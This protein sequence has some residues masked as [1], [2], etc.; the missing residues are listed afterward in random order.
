MTNFTPGPWK[1]VENG[2]CYGHDVVAQDGKNVASFVRYE[3]AIVIAQVP[4]MVKKLQQASFLL[5]DA[6]TIDWPG[7]EC[8]RS[9]ANRIDDLLHSIGEEE[10][11]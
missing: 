5:H 1:A 7:A 11:E 10:A 9:I 4:E 8:S 2:D 6:S 3:D